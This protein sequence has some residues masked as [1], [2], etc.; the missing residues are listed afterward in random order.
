[1]VGTGEGGGGTATRRRWRV[2]PTMGLSVVLRQINGSK[3]TL[4]RGS[5][6]RFLREPE[7]PQSL[8]WEDCAGIDS[9]VGVSRVSSKPGREV[10]SS[11]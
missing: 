1:M 3:G 9:S 4:G 10:L 7:V 8:L 5:S 6:H 11:C 2:A